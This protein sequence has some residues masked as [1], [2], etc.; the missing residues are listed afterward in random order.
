MNKA[1]PK[2]AA[3]VAR[4]G[5]GVARFIPLILLC[6]VLTAIDVHFVV[7]KVG[8]RGF[9]QSVEV[10]EGVVNGLPHWRIY[11]SRV[12]GPYTVDFLSSFFA[13]STA[14]AQIT[15]GA[16]TL[17]L[18]KLIIVF[19]RRHDL[20]AGP[21]FSMLLVGSFLFALLVTRPWLYAWDFFGIFA[22]TLFVVFALEDRPWTWFVPVVLIAFLN[23]ESAVFISAWM[24]MQGLLSRTGSSVPFAER[25]DWRMLVAGLVTAACGLLAVHLLRET[26]LVREIGPELFGFAAPSGTDWF[27]WKL[28]Q[29]INFLWRSMTSGSLLMPWLFT[30][31]PVGTMMIA[32][33]LAV[34]CFPR[35]TALCLCFFLLFTAI[36]MFGVLAEP[37]VLLETIPFFS[38]F[39]VSLYFRPRT[40][41][42]DAHAY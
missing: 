30:L 7:S 37:R 42:A 13:I 22:F 19:H 3:D 5:P 24:V 29:N 27:H 25:V 21:T 40:G 20:S 32:A 31:L 4:L 9:F 36:F 2:S 16:V 35:Y 1:S 15:F 11:Q 12:L 34:R 17:L 14:A 23:R 18:A 8:G 26:L 38:V 41:A 39:L 10:S 33:F 28:P 6:L